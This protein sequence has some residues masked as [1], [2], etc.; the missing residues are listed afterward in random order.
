MPVVGSDNDHHNDAAPVNGNGEHDA[1][2]GFEVGLPGGPAVKYGV[3]DHKEHHGPCGPGPNYKHDAGAGYAV[4]DPAGPGVKFGAG[5]H[6]QHDSYPC[7]EPSATHIPVVVP[8]HT[9]PIV[10]PS[11][12]TPPSYVAPTPVPVHS[13][14]LI[15][16]PA[17]SSSPSHTP[18]YNAGSAL[19]PTSFLAA[20]LPIILGMIY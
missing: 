8:A 10:I 1:G 14:P 17:P 12:T 18:V 19:A 20:A 2:A 7:P 3:G 4:G 6:D 13:T 15:P 11:V 9:T 5:T 16:H